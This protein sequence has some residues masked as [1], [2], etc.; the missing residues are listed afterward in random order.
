MAPTASPTVRLVYV[1]ACVTCKAGTE[2]A[3]D[4]ERPCRPFSRALNADRAFGEDAGW[5][6]TREVSCLALCDD[7]GTVA[8][9]MPEKRSH[10]LGKLSAAKAADLVS[11]SRSHRSS[12]TGVDFPC[13]RPVSRR[14]AVLRRM[15]PL[16]SAPEMWM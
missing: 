8:I 6:E 16:A 9:S 12:R 1:R 5:L 3:D 2:V 4:A 13:K 10:L 14:D 15:P 7:G 11:Y